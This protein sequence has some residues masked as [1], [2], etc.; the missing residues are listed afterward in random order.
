MDDKTKGTIDEIAG[1]V[2]T[3]AGDASGNDELAAE[4]RVQEARGV[5]QKLGGEIRER[6]EDA[7]ESVKRA[8]DHTDDK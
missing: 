4:G 7:A 6:F 1:K 3:V 8:L 5:L 2:K